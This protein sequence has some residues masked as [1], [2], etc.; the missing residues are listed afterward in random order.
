MRFLGQVSIGLHILVL[1]NTV[2]LILSV[3]DRWWRKQNAPMFFALALGGAESVV[4]I[5]SS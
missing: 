4:G 3:I 5:E 2:E 1:E